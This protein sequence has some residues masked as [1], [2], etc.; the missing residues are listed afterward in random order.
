MAAY[1]KSLLDRWSQTLVLSRIGP[2]ER[3]GMVNHYRQI[4]HEAQVRKLFQ[5]LVH[6]LLAAF[7]LH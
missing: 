4:A 7:R 5:V 1:G 3:I 2:R 6:L